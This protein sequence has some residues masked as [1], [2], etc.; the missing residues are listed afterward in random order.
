MTLVYCFVVASYPVP[1]SIPPFVRREKYG[2][3]TLVPYV[4]KVEHSHVTILDYNNFI[5]YKHMFISTDCLLLAR[6][7]RPH[8]GGDAVLYSVSI[9]MSVGSLLC[10][11]IY[12]YAPI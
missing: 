12:N 9:G 6:R 11:N 8:L 3:V 7:V 2:L 1:I 5:H 10:A 4:G